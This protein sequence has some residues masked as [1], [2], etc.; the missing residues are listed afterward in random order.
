MNDVEEAT[1]RLRT[2]LTDRLGIDHPILLAAMGDSAGGRL[3][4][5]VSN[6]GAL[7]MV[8]G[9]YADPVW[10]ERELQLVGD[11]RVGIGF[12]TFA[13][14][15]RPDT[16]RQAL[17]AAPVAVQLSFGDPRPYADAIKATG[18]ALICQVQRDDEVDQAIEAG[19]DVLIAQGQDAGGHGRPDRGT[20]SLVPSIV[21]RAG[22][23]PVV[24]AGGVADGRGL[25]GALALGAAG[26]CVGTR[27]L[28]T[29]ESITTAAEAAALV[30][31][32][33]DD[34]VRSPVID[35]VRGPAWPEGYDGRL[36]RN[37]LTERWDGD[38][39][40]LDAHR[41]ELHAAYHASAPDDYTMRALWAGEGLDLITAIVPAATIVERMVV[42][43]IDRLRAVNAAVV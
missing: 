4:A 14:D 32:G 21:D 35:L 43:A 33:G 10:L 29:E 22:S 11:A 41:D 19:A 42:E 36:V 28:A 25:A 31:H 37:A 30:A 15:E 16:L 27:F 24:A 6:A 26:V 1:P 40:G 34:T 17:E 2:A 12:V 20:F 18:A 5:A 23:I 39:A 8:G 7:G 38:L 9:G 3:A 13:L